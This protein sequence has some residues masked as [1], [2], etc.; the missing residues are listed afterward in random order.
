MTTYGPETTTDEVLL[1]HDLAG[2]HYMVTGAS[3]GLGE[4]SS[5]ALAQAGATVTM[6]A[7]NQSKLDKAIERIKST[8]PTARLNAGI[9]DLSDQQSIRDYAREFLATGATIDVLINNAGV[10][11]CPFGKTV[12]GIEMQ[13]GT[14]HIGHFLLT[15]LLMPA[16]LAGT[17]PRIVNL[18]SAGH[19][20]SDVNL[21][22]PN[23]E[24]SEYNAWESY[25]RSK[26]ANIHFTQEIVRRYGDR[27]QSF[28]VH[29]GV[30][31]TELGRHLTPELMNEMT[32]RVKSRSTSSSEAKETGALPFKSVEAGAATQVWASVTEDLSE[33]NG[34]YLGDC[35]LG[36]EGGNPSESGYLP[37][38]FN[39][40]T[41]EALWS[42]SEELVKQEFPE[43]T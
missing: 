10:M 2:R 6:L 22:D 24:K 15:N 39:R 5:R 1:G 35:Q 20:H 32:E 23:F 17:N 36:V 31:M 19:T 26:S 27:I 12:N 18:S 42:L 33:N 4:E 28:A 11:V 25:G 30:I 34:A 43:A 3:S 37:Y 21:V 14:N 38:I 16:I 9:I 8:N 29:P 41:A 7:R 40:E 13:F